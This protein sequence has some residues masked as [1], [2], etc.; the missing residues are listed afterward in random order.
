GLAWWVQTRWI[1]RQRRLWREHDATLAAVWRDE[2]D[3][4]PPDNVIVLPDVV[5]LP[6][7]GSPDL[8]APRNPV[9]P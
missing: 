7:V 2:S 6:D 1:D 8:L 9:T 5:V 3:A 4:E